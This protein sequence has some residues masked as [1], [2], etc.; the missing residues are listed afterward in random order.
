M[1]QE[2]IRIKEAATLVGRTVVSV[3]HWYWWAEKLTPEELPAPLPKLYRVGVRGDMYIDKAEIPVL[4]KFRDTI[5]ENY[6]I[7]NDYNRHRRGEVGVIQQER[8]EMLNLF[9]NVE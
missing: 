8:E 3:K 7:M 4:E 1:S 2:L 6:G 5:A 9:K